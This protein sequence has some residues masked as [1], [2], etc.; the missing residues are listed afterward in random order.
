MTE[1]HTY[2]VVEFSDNS[3]GIINSS[4]LTPRKKETFWPPTKDQKQYYKILRNPDPDFTD[5]KLYEVRCLYE[6]GK[7]LLIDNETV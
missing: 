4:W 1:L 2:S 7:F 5:W 6:S 3:V